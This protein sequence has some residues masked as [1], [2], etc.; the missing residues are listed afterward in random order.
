MWNYF[1]IL[2]DLAAHNKVTPV[3]LAIDKGIPGN[4]EADDIGKEGSELSFTVPELEPN[5]CR[6]CVG[7]ELERAPRTIQ[8]QCLNRGKVRK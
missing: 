1:L 2:N 4:E 8:I 7:L 3:W 6:I 5:L